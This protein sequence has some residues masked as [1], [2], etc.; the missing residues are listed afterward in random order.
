L[1]SHGCDA[2]RHTGTKAGEGETYVACH[3]SN[4]D[5]PQAV[6]RKAVTGKIQIGAIQAQANIEAED[7]DAGAA[8]GCKSA[9]CKKA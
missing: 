3:A 7:D 4:H 9:G 1:T 2:I 5:A 8:R 6:G